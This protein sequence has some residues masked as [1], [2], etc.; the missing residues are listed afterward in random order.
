MIIQKTNIAI[1]LALTVGPI[2]AQVLSNEGTF[3]VDFNKGCAPFTVSVTEVMTFDP[4][5]S[6]QYTYEGEVTPTLATTHTFDEPGIYQIA[7]ILGQDAFKFDTL[8]VEVLEPVLPDFRVRQCSANGIAITATDDTYDFYRVF[9]TDTDF[10]DINPGETTA[11]FIYSTTGAQPLRVRGIFNNAENNCGETSESVNTI[12][13]LGAAS[14]TGLSVATLGTTDGAMTISFELPENVI[15]DL[16]LATNDETEFQFLQNVSNS[17]GLTISGLNTIEDAYCFRLSVTDACTQETFRSNVICT[18]TL[19]VEANDGFNQVDWTVP[20]VL[21]DPVDIFKDGEFFTSITNS[22]QRS[23]MDSLVSCGVQNCYSINIT[24]GLVTFATPQECDIGISIS[25]PPPVNDITATVEGSNVNLTWR[26]SENG[27]ADTVRIRRSRGLQFLSQIASTTDS[28]FVDESPGVNFTSFVYD[29]SYAD[30]CG[31][32]SST[33]NIAQ[34]IFLQAENTTG[35]VYNLSWN[36][37]E[38]WFAGVANYFLQRLDPSGNLMEEEKVLSGFTE[39]VVLTN[40]DREPVTFRIR[41]ASLDVPELESFSNGQTFEFVPELFIP[42]AFTPNDDNVNDILLVEG[43]FVASLELKIF[44]RWGE[45]IF[46]TNDRTIGWDGTIGDKRAA[47]GT[48][49]YSLDFRDE[50]GKNFTKRGTFVLI[51]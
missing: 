29:I 39:Q 2:S 31:N 8:E 23:L 4:T 41:A 27:V 15:Y 17:S 11:P 3:S 43:T 25:D 42:G 33:S 26:I 48:Y 44:N 49:T 34:T 16:E 12:T 51:R 6:R 7:Q 36:A 20:F 37:Y 9:F 14:V 45:V 19:S 13:Q 28:S 47:S 24:Q 35:N 5:V 21:E 38:G 32:R 10:E 18:A 1:I 50:Q 46:F 22:D 40:L 30:E